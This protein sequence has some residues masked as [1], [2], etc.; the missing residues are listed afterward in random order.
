L[1]RRTLQPGFTL[2]EMVLSLAI[3]GLVAVC[4]SSV[5]VLAGKAMPS[6]R[7]RDVSN[8]ASRETCARIAGEI[9]SAVT[10]NT[11]GPASI[12]FTVP[13]RDDDGINE[14]YTYSWGGTP[15]DPILWTYNGSA[16]QVLVDNARAFD[17]AM[18]A[19]SV[20]TSQAAP[21][22]WSN[23]IVLARHVGPAATGHD[24]KYPTTLVQ[25][26]KPRLPVDSTGWMITRAEFQLRRAAGGSQSPQLQ[27]LVTPVSALGVPGFPSQSDTQTFATVTGSTTF[28]PCFFSFG[29]TP[30]YAPDTSALLSVRQT[31]LMP[32]GSATNVAFCADAS[33]S[34][35]YAMWTTD[36]LTWTTDTDGGYAC[37]M[38]GKVRR[39]SVTSVS[40]D[41]ADSVTVTLHAMQSQPSRVTARMQNR[42]VMP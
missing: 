10:I 12:D 38:Y 32:A 1:T 20:T 27:C 40:Q 29:T 16:N 19:D 3:I 36:G 6:P 21:D 24:V 4:I 26:F 37:V 35:A 13:D 31:I 22:A 7:D 25:H 2:V 33:D 28:V 17:I 9:A 42:P 39:P 15:G 41:L 11:M 8:V 5:T 34:N 23:E 14:R 18:S 30:T